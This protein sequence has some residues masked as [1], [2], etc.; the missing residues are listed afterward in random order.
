MIRVAEMIRV[1]LGCLL[2]LLFLPCFFRFL[3]ILTLAAAA[4]APA[5]HLPDGAVCGTLLLIDPF[6][7]SFSMRPI[8]AVNVLMSSS[9]AVP[10]VSFDT[11]C[12]FMTRS[13]SRSAM[14][15]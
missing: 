2:L 13:V 12:A 8:T 7:A 5:P 11:S 14:H 15:K 1:P 6:D 10:A 4:D 9:V 3:R